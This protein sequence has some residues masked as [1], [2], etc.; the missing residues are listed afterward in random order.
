M[1]KFL[2]LSPE[3]AKAI[4]LSAFHELVP[5]PEDE[6]TDFEVWL[7]RSISTIEEHAPPCCPEWQSQF[8]AFVNKG[9][10]NEEF[11]R[12]LE[13]CPVCIKASDW[14]F[15]RQQK[16]LQEIGGLLEN[17]RKVK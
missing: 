7:L 4:L 2:D 6:L 3:M 15:D 17:I 11:D 8:Y 13:Q 5:L 9:A 16:I 12:H 10:S 1:R 14:V